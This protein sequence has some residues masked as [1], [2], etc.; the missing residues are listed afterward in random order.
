MRDLA[1]RGCTRAPEGRLF[2]IEPYSGHSPPSFGGWPSAKQPRD[3]RLCDLAPCAL[4]PPTR[5]WRG[6]LRL[7][8]TGAI[9][10]QGE[11][12]ATC[13]LPW[14]F[15]S[16]RCSPPLL[17]APSVLRRASAGTCSRQAVR[18]RAASRSRCLRGRPVSAR[19]E[20]SGR[21]CPPSSP[22]SP[23]MRCPGWGLQRS[24]R[25]SASKP[26]RPP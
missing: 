13:R 10:R 23:P 6:N 9:S 16:C 11:R 18:V 22:S 26:L 14:V 1:H 19:R 24:R 20:P 21:A 5:R 4:A 17:A 25:L 3:L 12:A 8:W 15:S 2:L 7:H